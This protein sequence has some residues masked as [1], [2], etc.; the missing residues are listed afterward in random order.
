MKEFIKNLA[1]RN[2]PIF[3]IGL[4][5]LT[6]FIV[7]IICYRVNPRKETELTR[8]GNES[9]F[10]VISEEEKEI[11]GAVQP[12]GTEPGISIEQSL[13][14]T[15]GI[16]EIEF[17]QT[18]FVPK[19]SRAVQGQ[20]VRWTNKTDKDI[21]L[22]QRTSTYTEL[23]EPIRIAPEESF[24]YRLSEQEDWHYEE[25]LSKYFGTVEV[26]KVNN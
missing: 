10:N 11:E 2:K 9:N 20:A 22:K 24:S 5:T 21:F 26:Y 13:D 17:T 8:I 3:A 4:I 16:L 7:I 25:D 19:T 15:V 18:G 14:E 6:I 23:K 12:E 1:E